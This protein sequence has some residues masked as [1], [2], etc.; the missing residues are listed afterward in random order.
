[1]SSTTPHP[2]SLPPN[3]TAPWSPLFQSHMALLSSPEFTLASLS[4]SNIPI[5]STSTSTASASAAVTHSARH[6]TPYAPRLRTLIYR[7]PFAR[8]PRNKHYTPPNPPVYTS[9]MPTFTTDVRTSKVHEFF[10]SSAG[11]GDV[12]QSQGSGGGGEIEA[13]YWV[14]HAL[15]QWRIRGRAYVLGP[16]IDGKAGEES[17]GVRT[18]KSEIGA[19][20]RRRDVSAT[21]TLDADW[22]WAKEIEGQFGNLSPGMR[23]M[24]LNPSSQ[25]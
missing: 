24:L 2:A 18:V 6:P 10:A 4:P 13:C 11:H 20:M 14:K 22:T 5:T 16:D 7:G 1:M 19:G 12:A 8:L 15:T 25:T 9:D 3:P 23:G 17:S 21:T